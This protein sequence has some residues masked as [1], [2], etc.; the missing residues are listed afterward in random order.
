MPSVLPTTDTKHAYVQSMF[1]GIAPR[2]DLL[3]DV[4]TGGM[5]R[6]WKALVVR[7]SG[8][9]PGGRVLDACTG[10]GDIALRLAKAVGPEGEVIG[11]DFSPRMLEVARRR[12][13]GGHRITFVEG[14]LMALPYADDSFDALTVGYGLRNVTSIPGALQEIKR[15]LRP[16][17]KMVSLDLGKPTSPLWRKIF[18]AYFNNVVPI[19]GRWLTGANDA[20]SYLPESLADFP[21]QEGLKRLMAEA[22]FTGVDCVSLMGGAAA[23]HVGAKPL[24]TES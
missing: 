21:A 17:G 1:D 22:G 16:G 12:P 24:G 15:V 11:L 8:A 23:V 3:N 13:I 20:Y 14:D 19:L 7:L 6:G 18:Y 9:Q 2:Y 4:M 10:T 5:H